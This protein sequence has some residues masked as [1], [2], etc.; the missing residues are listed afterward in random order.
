ME[1]CMDNYLIATESFN[2]QNM[3]SKVQSWFTRIK[4]ILQKLVGA[5][6]KFVKETLEKIHLSSLTVNKNYY[7]DIMNLI[8]KIDNVDFS[9]NEKLKNFRSLV[10]LDLD[11]LDNSFNEL[12]NKIVELQD[13]EEN[14]SKLNPSSDGQIIKIPEAHVMNLKKRFDTMEKSCMSDQQTAS[15]IYQSVLASLTKIDQEISDNDSIDI[16]DKVNKVMSIVTKK[17]TCNIARAKL[18]QRLVNMIITHANK[19]KENKKDKNVDKSFDDEIYPDSNVRKQNGKLLQIGMSAEAFLIFCDDYQEAEESFRDVKKFD[20]NI[21]NMYKKETDIFNMPE[22]TLEDINKKLDAANNQKEQCLTLMKELSSLKP[23]IG[24]RLI[25]GL[26]KVVGIGT[27]I[28]SGAYSNNLI[29]KTMKGM[30]SSSNILK[31]IC[32]LIGMSVIIDIMK[33]NTTKGKKEI[34]T[35]LINELKKKSNSLDKLILNL[36]SKRNSMTN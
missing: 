17:N 10:K 24:D 6:G 18:M 25:S 36:E 28:G 31:S 3:K 27:S 13:I 1:I 22:K 19:L 14:I 34:I 29:S 23:D 2:V 8:H 35:K 20:K 5:I 33:S 4:T 11:A 32:V 12:A 9:L 16:L 26:S 7:K 21:Q 30:N 15:V